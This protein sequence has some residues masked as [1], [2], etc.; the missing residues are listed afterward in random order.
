MRCCWRAAPPNMP[1]RCCTVTRDDARMARLAEALAFFA[2]EAEVLRFPA[3][4]CLP[5]D[6]V[7][8][9]PEL[10]SDANFHPGAAAGAGEGS[11]ASM[12]TTVNAL[13]QLVP[14]R[15]RVP[16][17][18][19][20]TAH[21][22]HGAAG[23]AHPV[24][25]SER[26]RPRRHG[27]GAGRIRHARR[28]YRCVSLGQSRSGAARSVRRHDREHEKFRSGDAAQCRGADAPDAATGVG[29]VSRQGEYR[30]FSHRLARVVRAGGGRGSAV[31]FDI[32]G[33]AASGHGALGAAVPRHHGD[34]A[35]SICRTPPG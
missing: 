23:E 4:D 16:W 5:Y 12:L 27:D 1:D 18:Q 9:N 19:H 17:Q 8:P 25:G 13:V 11:R 20:G 6:R 33:Q 15:R 29:G 7:S 14:P 32:R 2:P 28:H 31:S 10:V 3:W 35:P 22:R 21:W 30:P 24:P 34:V 26:L